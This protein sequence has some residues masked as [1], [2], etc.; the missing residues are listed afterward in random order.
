[1]QN[2]VYRF[3]GLQL[4]GGLEKSGFG[5]GGFVNPKNQIRITNLRV[6][7]TRGGLKGYFIVVEVCFFSVLKHCRGKRFL[8]YF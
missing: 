5:G 4:R 3:T 6:R 8:N 7:F 1:M 2:W